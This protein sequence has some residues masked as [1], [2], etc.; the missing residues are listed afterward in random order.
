MARILS[1][2]FI[3][4]ALGLP[5]A[6]DDL[7]SPTVTESN[8]LHNASSSAR[9]DGYDLGMEASDQVDD[10]SLADDAGYQERGFDQFGGSATFFW[11]TDVDDTTDPYT[12]TWNLVNQP[13]DEV[14]AIERVAQ[15]KASTPFVAGDWVNVYR[16][17]TAGFNPDTEGDGGYAYDIPF[18]AKGDVYPY[19]LIAAD[20][21]A[22]IV[23]TRVGSGSLAVGAH[24]VIRA[25]LYGKLINTNAD[26]VSSDTTVVSVSEMGVL[27]AVGAGT[28]TIT[29]THPSGTAS[30]PISITVTT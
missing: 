12:V 11:P 24:D 13:G 7:D 28:A 4:L 5:S 20:T 19:T 6:I 16:L 9:W 30:T 14:V 21:P 15:A 27:T 29:A 2:S 17:E 3:T 22:A 1:N 25:T 23:T 10:R 8:A 18:L 26:W